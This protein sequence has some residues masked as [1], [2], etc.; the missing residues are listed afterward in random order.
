MEPIITNILNNIDTNIKQEF[1]TKNESLLAIKKDSK[2]VEFD[3]SW[4]EKIEE[5]I[6]SLDNIVRNPRKFIS[7]EEEIVPVERAK[8]ISMESIKHLATHTSLIQEFDEEEGT[9]TPS[10]VLNINKEESFD[11]YENRFIYSLLLN[12]SMFI[13]KRKE[14]TKEG[15]N[16]KIN[17][18]FKYTSTTKIGHEN[19]KI[20]LNL[21][22][23]YFEDLVGMNPSGMS[24]SERLDR[25][26]LIISD[27][28]KSPFMKELQLG[29][30]IM[31][32][33]PIRKTNV[34]LKNLNFQKALELW[35]FIEQYNVLDKIETS[36]SKDYNDEGKLKE[37][38]DEA[39]LLD[40]LILNI[41]EQKEITGMKKYYINKI[42][43]DFV[44]NND[45]NDKQF[46]KIINH[47]F[48]IVYKEKKKRENRIESIFKKQFDKFKSDNKEALECLR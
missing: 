5:T 4:L 45:I 36:D 27:F 16:S 9:V 20:D 6:E 28:I 26:E 15:S 3:Y 46:K 14:L 43:K 24:L 18:Q 7:Q 42:I 38:M 25:V 29:H 34:I 11:I 41:A 2:K 48:E 40:Y 8:K 30:I 10:K 23:E 32:K 12:L 21:E 44:N 17:K 39:F 33:S 1:L 35:E 19:I 22:T 37:N 47:E 13:A 31:V